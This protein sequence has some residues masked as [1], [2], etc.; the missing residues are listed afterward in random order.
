MTLDEHVAIL[1]EPSVAEQLNAERPSGKALSEVGLHTV[2]ISLPQQVSDDVAAKEA[3]AFWPPV[4]SRTCAAGQVIDGLVVSLTVTLV[5]HEL[6]FPLKS[7]AVYPT[8]VVP[9]G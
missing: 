2:V 3:T 1:L 8:E 5:A 9:S 7:V 4:H 6:E